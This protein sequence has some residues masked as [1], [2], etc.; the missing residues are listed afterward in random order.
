M[1]KLKCYYAHTM[2][3]YGST[4]EAFDIAVLE[5]LGF[6]VINPNSPEIKKGCEE[7]TL[8]HGKASVMEYFADIVSNC[9]LLAFRSLPSGEILSGISAEIQEAIRCDIPVI[10]LPC[11]LDKRMQEYPETKQYLIELGFYKHRV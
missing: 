2:V 4:I 5:N 6:E 3:S 10:E 7:F 8:K 11:S 9:D 1:S